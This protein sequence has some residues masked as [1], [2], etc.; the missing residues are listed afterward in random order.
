MA[1][2]IA[3]IES[4]VD[5]AMPTI[6]NILAATPGVPAR[7]FKAAI[8][9]QCI[10][11]NQARAIANCE[12]PSIINCALTF[13]GLGLMPDG[14]T[15]QAF[16]LPFG[17]IATPVVGYK[18]YNTLGDRAGRTITGN[19]VRDGEILRMQEGSGALIDHIRIS[20]TGHPLASPKNRITWAWASASAPNRTPIIAALQI[21]ELMAVMAKSPAV[22]K[23]RP[24]PW[25]DLNIGRPAMFEKTA[26]RRLARSM[27]LLSGSA[28]A[29]VVADAVEQQFDVTGD[30]HYLLPGQD[31]KLQVTNGVSKEPVEI[32]RPRQDEPDPTM[33]PVFRACINAGEP[34]SEFGTILEWK[35]AISRIVSLNAKRKA[36]LQKF[37]EANRAMFGA[38][39]SVGFE[40][41]VDAIESEIA[42]HLAA[43]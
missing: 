28:G 39:K 9:S 4:A 2:D 5:D 7:S 12:L 37:L 20:E 24:S 3:V 21:D 33:P 40:K 41:D 35:A 42:K 11:S 13:S 1:N 10:N 22:K 36:P 30:P 26:K 43:K 29:Y 15:G 8:L 27:P 32:T 6:A 38:V 14:V 34:A 17:G 19:V 31:G 25:D 23:G 18:G 16:M